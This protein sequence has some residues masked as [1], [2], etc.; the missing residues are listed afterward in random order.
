MNFYDGMNSADAWFDG[1]EMIWL[2]LIVLILL[3]F[4]SLLLIGFLKR[5][6]LNDE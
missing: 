3:F 5:R 2:G 1:N 4:V 6:K